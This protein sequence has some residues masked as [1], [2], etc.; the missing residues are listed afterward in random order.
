LDANKALLMYGKEVLVAAIDW[1]D[2]VA[3]IRWDG[4]GTNYHAMM[5]K[6]ERAGAL[7]RS[8]VYDDAAA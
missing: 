4:I 1:C 5:R 3:A 2:A 6:K 8:I 7:F